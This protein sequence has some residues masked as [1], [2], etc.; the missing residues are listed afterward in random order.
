M[1]SFISIMPLAPCL[2]GLFWKSR[3]WAGISCCLVSAAMLKEPLMSRNRADHLSLHIHA[4]HCHS[5]YSH[6][7]HEPSFGPRS[8]QYGIPQILAAMFSA[9][10]SELRSSS[11]LH[12]FVFL[13]L[14]LTRLI[15]NTNH[16]AGLC[17]FDRCSTSISHKLHPLPHDSD[18]IRAARLR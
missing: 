10:C 17:T 16:L 18:L 7:S 11:L 6:Y 13:S 15:R 1:T 2:F 4:L 9:V 14:L 5:V 3:R 8:S 12:I